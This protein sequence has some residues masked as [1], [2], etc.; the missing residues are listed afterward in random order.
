[1]K[2]VIER[3]SFLDALSIGSQMASKSKG[4]AILSNVKVTIKDNMATVSSYDTEVAIAKKVDI[5]E[6]DENSTFCIEPKALS[7]ILN[8][9]KDDTITLEFNDNICNIYHSKGLIS[10]PYESADDFPTPNIDKTTNTYE[11]DAMILY[12][13]LKEGKNFVATT[14][15][16][17]AFTGVLLYWDK[18]EFGVAS[19]DTKVLYH[20]KIDFPCEEDNNQAIVCPKA[21]DSLLPMIAKSDKVVVMNSERNIVFKT[22]DATLASVK[23]EERYPNFKV[24]IV[25]NNPIEVSIN[26]NDFMDSIKRAMLGASSLTSLLKLHISGM[27]MKIESEDFMFSKKATEECFC[28]CN[29]GEITIGVKGTYVIDAINSMEGETITLKFSD[30]VHPVLFCDSENENKVIEL[31]PYQVEA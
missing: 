24:I 10:M 31:M 21:I 27:S 13:W 3:K 28:N 6:H 23:L 16:R 15:L 12:N 19:T 29:G 7:A 20:D 22:E 9:L 8:S 1:M 17:P 5:I 25:K 4:L 14:D 11:V 30:E 26:K 18:G 2:I